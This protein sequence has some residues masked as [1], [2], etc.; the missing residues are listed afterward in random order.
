MKYG[1]AR[2]STNEDKQDT[3]TTE[4]D[5]KK[6]LCAHNNYFKLTSYRKNYTKRTSGPTEGQY[7]QLEFAYLR[8]LARIDMFR[9]KHWNVHLKRL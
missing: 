8:E 5:A 1:Y 7:A 2:C 6:H 4:E 3:I 9:R